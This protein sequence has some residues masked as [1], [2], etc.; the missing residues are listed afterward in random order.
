MSRDDNLLSAEVSALSY[1]SGFCNDELHNL[2]SSPYRPIIRVIKTR[3]V[4]WTGNSARMGTAE[5]Q[6]FGGQASRSWEN[7]TV[8]DLTDMG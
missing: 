4:R 7:N 3:K 6:H 8:M 2:H 1:I 5:M